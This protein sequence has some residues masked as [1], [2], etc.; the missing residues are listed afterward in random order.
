MVKYIKGVDGYIHVGA[1]VKK[2]QVLR[3]MQPG[4]KV[5]AGASVSR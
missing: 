3:R 4:E 1:I 5:K 2:K